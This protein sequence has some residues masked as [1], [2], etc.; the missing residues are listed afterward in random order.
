[1][2]TNAINNHDN[3]AYERRA[4]SRMEQQPNVGD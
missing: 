3:L 4:E 2:G 1:M